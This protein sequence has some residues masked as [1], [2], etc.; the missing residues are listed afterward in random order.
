MIQAREIINNYNALKGARAALDAEIEQAAALCNPAKH[1]SSYYNRTGSQD[2]STVRPVSVVSD[3]AQMSANK[4]TR[5]FFSNLFPSNVR[6]FAYGVNAAS[7]ESS[8]PDSVK[9]F[10]TN[11]SQITYDI[12]YAT[13]FPVEM[14]E[15]VEDSTDAGTTVISCRFD[16][17]RILKFKS[18]R[19]GKVVCQRSADDD[20]DTVYEEIQLSAQQA[21]NIFNLPTDNL[22]EKLRSNA[23]SGNV[24]RNDQTVK[25][26]HYVA[27]QPRRWESGKNNGQMNARPVNGVEGKAFVSIYVEVDSCSIV[28]TEGFDFNPFVVGRIDNCVTGD[29]YGLSPALRALRSMK[30]HNKMSATMVSAAESTIKPS[31]MMDLG[32]YTDLVAE[33]FFEP[34]SV[35]V[36][37]SQGGKYNAP[38][39]YTPPANFA[40]TANLIAESKATI[41]HFF[42]A[43]LFTLL[44]QMNINSGRQRTAREIVELVN[45]R[46]SQI[47]TTVSRFLDETV[48]PLLKLV[49]NIILTNTSLYGDVT[50]EIMEYLDGGINLQYFTPM[51]M[52]ARATRINGTVAAVEDCAPLLQLAP[53]ALDILDTDAL[54][55]DIFEVRGAL[56][57]HIRDKRKVEAI[58]SDRAQAAQQQQAVQSMVDLAGTQDLNAAPQAGSVVSSLLGG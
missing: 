26:I 46:N 11:A 35:N 53:E 41:D 33:F 39:F 37:N 45:E 2:K 36:Y 7:G 54:I 34:G 38:Q 23:A 25:F 16:P 9:R 22:S 27:P 1:G 28:R 24:S 13:N 21:V 49:F 8:I 31:V 42:S 56:P 51:A 15:I 40:H 29:V 17:R 30:L 57:A 32:A 50:P 47:L 4:Y 5:G 20:I 19:L 43:D 12:L 14:L 18:H 52:A 6:W 48:S 3:Y 55:R 58:R 10:F 44:Q